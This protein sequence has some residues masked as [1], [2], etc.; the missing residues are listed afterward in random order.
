[1]SSAMSMD[2][3]TTSPHVTIS[4]TNNYKLNFILAIPSLFDVDLE[5]VNLKKVSITDIVP[6]FDSN[7]A[8]YTS[9][10]GHKFRYNSSGKIH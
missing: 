7:I 4:L 9:K 1:M 8:Q 6:D 2:W 3:F 10:V 5:K